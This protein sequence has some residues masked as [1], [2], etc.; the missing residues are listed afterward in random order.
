MALA[1]TH[2]VLPAACVPVLLPWD[3]ELRFCQV[4]VEASLVNPWYQ[5]QTEAEQAL[6]FPGFDMMESRDILLPCKV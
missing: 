5:V 2:E 4:A 1:P 3:T 6:H